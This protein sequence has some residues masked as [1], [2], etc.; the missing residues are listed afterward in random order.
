MKINATIRN[1]FLGFLLLVILISGFPTYHAAD[2]NRNSEIDLQ[3]AI[4]S[5]RAFTDSINNPDSFRQSVEN[6]VMALKVVSGLKKVIKSE[7][8]NLGINYSGDAAY[9]VTFHNFRTPSV[10]S[11]K[12]SDRVFFHHSYTIL[13]PVPPPRSF[14]ISTAC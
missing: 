8:E 11:Q 6:V 14:L 9:L 5:V 1:L 3:D 10:Q 7:R 4:M 13:P 2:M 12:V